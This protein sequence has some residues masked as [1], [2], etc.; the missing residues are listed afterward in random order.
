L[1]GEVFFEFLYTYHSNGRLRSARVLRDGRETLLE[2][3]EKKGRRLSDARMA[4]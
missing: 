2:Y 1:R 4:F 3:D